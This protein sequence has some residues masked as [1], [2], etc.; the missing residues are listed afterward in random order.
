MLLLLLISNALLGLPSYGDLIYP[1]ND[2]WMT[3]HVHL[4][5]LLWPLARSIFHPD[6]KYDS[7]IDINDGAFDMF[8]FYSGRRLLGNIYIDDDVMTSLRGQIMYYYYNWIVTETGL[9]LHDLAINVIT[10]SS[11]YIYCWAINHL[12]K[13]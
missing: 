9:Y 1:T 10:S 2:S 13:N 3:W 12:N 11:I 6:V 8:D 4:G 5:L 7:L